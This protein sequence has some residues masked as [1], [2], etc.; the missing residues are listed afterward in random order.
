MSVIDTIAKG[1]KFYTNLYT[2]TTIALISC[3]L[4]VKCSTVGACD[5]SRKV[6]TE[7]TFGVISHGVNANYTQVRKGF[8]G[9]S[10]ES[11]E[12]KSLLLQDSHC[13]WLIE[14]QNKS[15]FI[16]LKFLTLRT[17]CSYDYVRR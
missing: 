3:T 6:F 10:K 9:Q 16:T 7:T 15:Q 2:L 1:N 8:H 5:K 4:T 17:E 14:A 12:H 13:E 11:S